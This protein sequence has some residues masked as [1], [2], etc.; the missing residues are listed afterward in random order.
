MAQVRI[1]VEQLPP[2]DKNGDHAFQ[3]RIISIDKNQRS[4]WS[5]LYVVKS[6]GQYRPLES[7]VV[8]VISSKDVGLTW[9]TPIIY[10]NSASLS[11]A[12]ISHNHSQDFKQHDADIFVQWNSGSTMADFEYH[13]RVSQD[14]TSVSIPISSYNKISELTPLDL[15]TFDQY[16]QMLSISSDGNTAIIGAYLGSASPTP[17]GGVAY[18]FTRSGT[19]WTQQAKLAPSDRA[20][21]DNFGISV[22]ISEDGNTVLIG[23]TGEDTSPNS[24]NGAVYVFTRSGTTWT[25]QAKLLASDA[26]SSDTFGFSSSISADGNTALIG[27]YLEDTS[28]NT[29]NGAAYVFTRSGTTWTQQ[30][31]LLA[32]DAASND[33]FGLSVDISSNGN[34]ALIGAPYESTSPNTSN[35]AVYVFTRSGTTWTQR[36]KIVS[37]DATSSYLFGGVV[38]ISGDGSTFVA[39]SYSSKDFAYVYTLIGDTWRQQAKLFS[40][41]NLL[42]YNFGSDLSISYDG[43]TIAVGAFVTNSGGGFYSLG[44]GA[45]AGP[46]S[47]ESGGCHI[48]T[49]LNSDWTQKLRIIDTSLNSE[50]FGRTVSI[51]GDGKTL[52]LGIPTTDEV[53]ING[54]A[55][56]YN[57]SNANKFRAIGVVALKDI[58]KK[59][60]FEEDVDYQTRLNEYL[61][62]SGSV[63]GVYDLFKIFD[64]GII[65]V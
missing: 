58:P 30:A 36:Q 39:S 34:T 42:E 26:A 54:N 14:T 47:T 3:F 12:S 29:N 55:N 35:G 19:T 8:S 13:A 10:N 7:N 46:V 59:R 57:L 37:E 38:S 56:I 49:R 28:P 48:F 41:E 9:D 33:N 61:G 16:G 21:S 63:Q 15:E 23:A 22:S 20:A 31:K 45:T 53:S 65:N 18:V 40:S 64:T 24:S 6:I 2:P 4:T 62:I 44:I 51:S 50:N 32:S 25:Q 11:S 43:N 1:P 60:I 5:Q 52:L 17:Y 27:A